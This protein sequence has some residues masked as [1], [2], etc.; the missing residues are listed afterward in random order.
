[1]AVAPPKAWGRITSIVPRAHGGNLDNKELVAG[2][3]LYLPVFVEG[4]LF[5][6]GDGHGAQGD[7]E[8]SSP[9]SRPPCKAPSRSFCARI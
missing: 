1:M 7:G 3:T 9:P 6:C 8:V 5:S 4:G 2:S